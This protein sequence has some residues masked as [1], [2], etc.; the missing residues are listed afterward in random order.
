MIN[1][2]APLLNFNLSSEKIHLSLNER[3][4]Q[5]FQTNCLSLLPVATFRGVAM[6]RFWALHEKSF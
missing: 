5:L 3:R 1:N 2:F 4:Y 6:A